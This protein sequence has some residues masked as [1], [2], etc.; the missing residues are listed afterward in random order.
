MSDIETR[1]SKIDDAIQ[2]LA[3]VS[4]DLS[5]MLAVQEHRLTQQEKNTDH[6]AFLIEKRREDLETK[7]K[8]VYDT[9]REEDGAILD[10]IKKSR[11]AS[12]IHHERLEAKVTKLEKLALLA[13]GS[14]IT[15]GF[16]LGLVER[17]FKFFT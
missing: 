13:T 5:K 15:V 9:M 14:A 7:L 1:F 3:V 17:Y 10:E 16:I 11:V 6:I 8:E 4:S 2:R 12:D